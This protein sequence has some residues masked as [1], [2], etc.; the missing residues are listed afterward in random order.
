M[1]QHDEEGNDVSGSY[2]GSS[3]R[4]VRGKDSQTVSDLP[5]VT[6]APPESQSRTVCDI[7]RSTGL[8]ILPVRYTLVPDS[9][10]VDLGGL[11]PS[12]VPDADMSAA[13]LAHAL[14]TMRQGMLYLYYEKGPC[15]GSLPQ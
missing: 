9:C 14:R 1:T 13:G 2:T 8:A 6:A 15:G 5:V 12:H 7:C 4:G 3:N 10:D 11:S